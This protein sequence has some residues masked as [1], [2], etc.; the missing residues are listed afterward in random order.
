MVKQHVAGAFDR[1]RIDV[2]A[3]AVQRREAKDGLSTV[4]GASREGRFAEVALEHV[5]LADHLYEVLSRAA[6]EVVSDGHL[7]AVRNQQLDEMAADE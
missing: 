4:G 1:M 5:D 7:C 6:G 2:A 3:A